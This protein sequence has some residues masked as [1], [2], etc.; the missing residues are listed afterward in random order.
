MYICKDLGQ[1]HE[2]AEPV[3]SSKEAK[4]IKA[5]LLANML[6]LGN[7]ARGLSAIQI[8]YNKQACVIKVNNKNKFLIAPQIIEH[9]EE[10]DYGAEKCLSIPDRRI[11][12]SRYRCVNVQ[13]KNEKLED[14]EIVLYADD[15]RT[16]QHEI[17]HLNG[18]LITDR[19]KKEHGEE[20]QV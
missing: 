7:K 5:K 9:S 4:N 15:A 10:Q 17:D 1:L 3:E 20:V 19:E 13:Y 2:V 18:I 14:C 16:I 6:L 11:C 8:G 12:V